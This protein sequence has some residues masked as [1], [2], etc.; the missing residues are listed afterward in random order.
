MTTCPE[1]GMGY[2]PYIPEDHKRH[3]EYHDMIVNGPRTPPLKSDNVMWSGGDDRITFV[4]PLSPLSQRLRAAALARTANREMRYDMPLY[5]E[6]DPVDERNVHLFLYHKRNRGVGLLI[7]EL[8]GHIWKCTWTTAE[9]PGCEELPG[10][11]PIWSV[12]FVWVHAKY[13]ST[14]IATRL[15]DTG[16]EYLGISRSMIGLYTPFSE[17]GKKFM[18]RLYP[19]EFLVAK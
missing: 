7:T 1:C 4:T 11:A 17:A 15:F 19:R 2:V 10:H 8:R 6:Y 9:I 13:R 14:G 3:R 18:R 5:R 16:L 12:I